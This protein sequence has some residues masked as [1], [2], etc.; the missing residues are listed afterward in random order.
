MT[1]G[2]EDAPSPHPSTHD[3]IGRWCAPDEALDPALFTVEGV[4]RLGAGDDGGP[5]WRGSITLAVLERQ[6]AGWQVP[7]WWAQ[8]HIH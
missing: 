1:L 2:T 5:C 3:A 7:A 6:V 4:L 8:K